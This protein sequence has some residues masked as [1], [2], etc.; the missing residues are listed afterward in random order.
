MLNIVNRNLGQASRSSGYPWTELSLGLPRRHSWR[1]TAVV[2]NDA[3]R[4][5]E[6]SEQPDL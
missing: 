5:V 3:L 6:T 4:W 2:A 1:R